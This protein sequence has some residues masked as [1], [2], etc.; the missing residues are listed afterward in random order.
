MRS[1]NGGTGDERFGDFT[2][3]Q[4]P[5]RPTKLHC[6]VR[7]LVAWLV[8]LPLLFVLLPFISAFALYGL[9]FSPVYLL[10][11]DRSRH[12]YESVA[13]DRHRERL[14]KWRGIYSRMNFRQRVARALLVRDRRK[15]V[16]RS[17]T[18]AIYQRRANAARVSATGTDAREVS[19][20]SA[21]PARSWARWFL[22]RLWLIVLGI[23]ICAFY[24]LIGVGLLMLGHY[25]EWV[26]LR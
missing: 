18:A 7:A 20:P 26:N 3:K 6:A 23:Y 15:R 14:K 8:L 11:P 2:E 24:M 12:K 21:L 16:S 13:N 17:L 5:F 4:D 9:F 10:Y 19:V 25:F 1:M 22:E